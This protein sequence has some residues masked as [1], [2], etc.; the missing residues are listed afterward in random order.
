MAR[1]RCTEATCNCILTAGAGII[2]SGTGS[3]SDPW[4]IQAVPQA[5]GAVVVADT[6][7]IDMQQSGNG[8]PTDPII[9]SGRVNMG[10]LINFIPS[11]DVAWILTGSGH[12][13]DPF[14]V[15]IDVKCIECQDTVAGTTGQVLTL[16]ADKVYR[17]QN[18]SVPAGTIFVGPGI[19]GDGSVGNPLRVDVCTYADLKALCAT[20]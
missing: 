1:C 16:G 20:P 8:V 17:P 14:N 12:D 11:G 2:L 3:A 4:V 18:V 15:G 7:S 10:A 13:T 19:T 5:T 9:I 6:P